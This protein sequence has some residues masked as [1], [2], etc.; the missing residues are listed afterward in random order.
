MGH[1]QTAITESTAVF[2]LSMEK[3]KQYK[4]IMTQL[5]SELLSTS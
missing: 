1:V 2:E 3:E 4:E 5:L